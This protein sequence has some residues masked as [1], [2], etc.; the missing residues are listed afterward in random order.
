MADL[1]GATEESSNSAAGITLPAARSYDGDDERNW[2]SKFLRAFAPGLVGLIVLFGG[3]E[4]AVRSSHISPIEMVA[5]SAVFK[6]LWREPGLY[7]H[8][9]WITLQEAFWGFVVAFVVAIAA[10]ILMSHSKVMDRALGPIVVILQVTPIIA[11]GP[12]LVIWLGFGAAPKILM[13]ALITFVPLVIN[14]TVG[15][16]AVDAST[17]E[18]MQSVNASK[19]EIFLRLRVP[20]SLPYLMSALRVCVGLALIG[21]VVA[22]FAGSSEGLGYVMIVGQK[23]LDVYEVWAAIYVLIVMGIVL[24]GLT[25]L[26]RKRL[27]RWA[28]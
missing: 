1:I 27:L 9:A 18:L 6:E 22:E 14:A 23:Q 15:F 5:P 4:I 26:L 24:V 19:T 7:R 17:L 16:R 10:A 12:P 8:H 21:A 13:A 20:H 28:E 3:W 25:E 11:L 2:L